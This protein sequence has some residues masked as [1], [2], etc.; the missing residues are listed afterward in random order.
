MKTL[1]LP[2]LTGLSLLAAPLHAELDRPVVVELFTSQGCSAC[3]EADAML[4]ELAPRDDIIALALHVDYWDYIGWK[5]P[6]G[7]PAHAE[8]QRAYAAVGGRR[9]V[10]TPELIVQGQTDIMGAKPMKLMEAI[11]QHAQTAPT[12]ALEI[13]RTG[14]ALQIRAEP[15]GADV[16]PAT[17]H[18]LRYSPE[19]QTKVTRGENAGRMMTHANIVHGWTVLGSWDGATPLALQAEAPGEAPVVVL[20]QEQEAG[21]GPGPILAAARLR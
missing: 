16:G 1:L 10:F 2:L 7:D 19:E 3:P 13:A 12:V 20:I 11:E 17:V 14:A 6:F 9:S 15:L 5:D 4:A 18:L 8:R 21:G